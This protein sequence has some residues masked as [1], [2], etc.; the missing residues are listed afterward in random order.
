[1][2][3]GLRVD[4][5]LWSVRLFKTRTAAAKACSSGHVHVA[6]EL[7]RSAKRVTK[8]DEVRIKRRHGITE[9]IVEQLLEKRV[10]ATLAA[11][12]YVD[13]SP[14]PAPRPVDGDRT[15]WSARA[16]TREPGEGR[17][18]KRDRR[19]LDDFRGR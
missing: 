12:A 9:V 19:Q 18:T 17:P 2:A 8:G 4:R 5:W 13:V 10:S 16:P 7:A 1:M 6:G 15:V 3:E 11:E 14:P